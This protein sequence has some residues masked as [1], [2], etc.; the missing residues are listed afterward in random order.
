MISVRWTPDAAC[1][2]T[3]TGREG[4]QSLQHVD[5]RLDLPVGP[6]LWPDGSIDL[7]WHHHEF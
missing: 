1:F 6:D 4:G 7:S 5:L 3:V 2:R